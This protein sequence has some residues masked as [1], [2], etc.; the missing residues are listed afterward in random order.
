[1]II[2]SICLSIIT[3]ISGYKIINYYK[4]QAKEADEAFKDLCKKYN[5]LKNKNN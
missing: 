5:Q 1:M 4:K 2:S 3:F